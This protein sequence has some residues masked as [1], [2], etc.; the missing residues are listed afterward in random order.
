M[1]HPTAV[2]ARARARA[3]RAAFDSAAMRTHE[4]PR[5]CTCIRV[6]VARSLQN[7]SAMAAPLAPQRRL[8]GVAAALVGSSSTGGLSAQR[9]EQARRSPSSVTLTVSTT[10]P[11]K[12][13]GSSSPI[14]SSDVG[15]ALPIRRR[16]CR[17]LPISL[18][19]APGRMTI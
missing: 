14:C 15:K 9:Q 5:T 18:C 10:R 7:S 8:S 12:H 3:A 19:C 16:W 2:G 4:S 13:W 11:G 1:Q 6:P 17:A